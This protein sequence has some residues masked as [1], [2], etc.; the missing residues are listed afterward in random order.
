M[1]GQRIY[2]TKCANCHMPSGEGLLGNIPPLAG[3]SWLRQRRG[4]LACVVRYGQRGPIEV[5]GMTYDGVMAGIPELSDTEITN[6]LNYVLTSWGN[7]EPVYSP[8]EV[9]DQLR[10]CRGREKV[11]VE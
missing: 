1:Q 2:E 5:N 7:A 8:Q 6:V 4:E 3:S 10:A 9:I 11:R